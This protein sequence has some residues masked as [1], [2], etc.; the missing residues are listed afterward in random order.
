MTNSIIA[1]V[2]SGRVLGSLSVSGEALQI[3]IRP[4]LHILVSTIRATG[5]FQVYDSKT[6]VVEYKSKERMI[7]TMTQVLW[8]QACCDL[9]W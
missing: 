2:W 4:H 5:Y 3:Q 1:L 6:S 9:D 8:R 7:E